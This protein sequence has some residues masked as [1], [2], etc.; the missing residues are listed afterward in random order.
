M[1]RV[2]IFDYDVD[3]SAISGNLEFQGEN[4]SAEEKE[5]DIGFVK[6]VHFWLLICDL[7][8]DSENYKYWIRDLDSRFTSVPLSIDFVKEILVYA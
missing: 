1:D 3:Y 4:I 5:F 6:Q 8:F 7:Q 2:D